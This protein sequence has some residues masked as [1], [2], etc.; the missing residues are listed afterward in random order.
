MYEYSHIFF[1][2]YFQVSTGKEHYLSRAFECSVNHRG[3]II[4]AT[5]GFYGSVS[6]KSIVK[7]DD[8]MVEMRKG[9]YSSYCYELYDKDGNLL[10]SYGG[11][12]L[13]DNGYHKW[14]T[15]AKSADLNFCKT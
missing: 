5:R 6:G 14:S 9:K 2:L 1:P 4:S 13:C 12:T 3:I 8:A 15:I 11:Y 10:K 7:F